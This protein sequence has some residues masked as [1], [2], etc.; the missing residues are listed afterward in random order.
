MLAAL[1]PLLYQTTDLELSCILKHTIKTKICFNC[2]LQHSWLNRANV[3]TKT[4]TLNAALETW[5]NATAPNN[6]TWL[7]LSIP[8]T[9][10]V[11]KLN[12]VTS[13]VNQNEALQS[14]H[15]HFQ[16]F[17]GLIGDMCHLQPH[18]ELLGNI[19]GFFNP[20][21]SQPKQQ[22]KAPS[23]KTTEERKMEEIQPH[24]PQRLVTLKQRN[25]KCVHHEIFSLRSTK[26]AQ[27]PFDIKP[28]ASSQNTRTKWL[29]TQ[30]N[31][32]WK[33]FIIFQKKKKNP[34]NFTWW[35]NAQT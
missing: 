14:Q 24:E 3:V 17:M 12:N 6:S 20:A 7:W 4:E 33:L 25:E 19:H 2:H 11:T 9:R 16:Q 15:Q 22:Q 23:Q 27:N 32:L 28:W 13:I 29:N 26:I 21:Q 31:L 30:H 10:T 1:P 18:W 5:K 34:T 35:V 8:I